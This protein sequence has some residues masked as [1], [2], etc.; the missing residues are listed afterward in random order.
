MYVCV[1][2]Y[3]H[4]CKGDCRGQGVGYSEPRVRSGCQLS[5]VNARN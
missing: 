5:G 1:F 2:V 4:M 3:V